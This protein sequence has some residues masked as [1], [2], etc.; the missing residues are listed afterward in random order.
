MTD[1]TYQPAPTGKQYEV[2]LSGKVQRIA[3]II[4]IVG[5]VLSVVGL[6]VNPDRFFPAYLVA[7]TFYTTVSLGGLFF[8]LLHHTAGATW[9]VVIRRGAEALALNLPWLALFFIPVVL[10]AHYLFHWSHAEAVAHDPVLQWKASYLNL[11][12]FTVRGVVYFAIWSALALVLSWF[13]RAQDSDGDPIHTIRLRRISAPAMYLFAFSITFA[14]F[15]WLMSLEPHWYSTIFG[16]YVFVGGFLAALAFITLF[17]L[18]LGRR[19][20]LT[21]LVGLEHYHDLGKLIFAFT[22]FWAYIGG[23][24]YFL[25]WYANI[26]EETVWYLQRWTGSWKAVSLVIIFL[27]FMFPFLALIFYRSKRNFNVLLTVAGALLSMHYLDMY[28]LVMPTFS[29]SGATFSWIDLATVAGMG[30]LLLW[31]F[32]DRFGRAAAVPFND[33]LFPQ[34]VEHRL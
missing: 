2:V 23:S 11:G 30:G 12:S 29:A 18:W 9:S 10:G 8:T 17:Y 33:P 31:R 3:L 28:W 24:Q 13:S 16:V 26:P 27:H 25:I 1:A 34:S 21:E 19:G 6:I 14:A 5:A 32:L 7:F 22:V 15:D 4:G 20:R